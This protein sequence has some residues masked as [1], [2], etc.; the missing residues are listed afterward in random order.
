[1]K[2]IIFVWLLVGA[3]I[4]SACSTETSKV[5]HVD[6]EIEFADDLGRVVC[7]KEPQRTAAM[8]GSFAQIWQLAGGEVCATASDA[9]DDLGLELAED[10]VNLGGTVSQSLELLL[11]AKPDFILASTNT[12]QNLEWKDT[13]ESIGIPVAY[14]DVSDFEDYLR[15]LDICTDITGRKDLYEENGSK[16]KEEIEEILERNREYFSDQEAP[17]ILSMTASASFVKAKNSEN[18]VL[19]TMLKNM[20]CVNIADS[21]KVLL[22]NLSMEHILI[23]DPDY[24]FIAQ[25]GDNEEGMRQ[26]VEQMMMEHPVWKQLSAVKNGRVYFMEKRLFSLKPNHQWAEAYRILEE[27]LRND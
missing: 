18:N 6:N 27:I 12:R 8:L 22:E 13:L 17:R 2:K 23:S 7:I 3:L 14:F 4:F 24:I 11:A 9:W 16:V 1:M 10:T 19:G 21:D 25:R 5:A 26:Y 15:M 20:G